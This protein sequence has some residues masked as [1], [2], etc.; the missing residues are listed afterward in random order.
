MTRALITVG[1]VALI[2]IATVAA[3][4]QTAPDPD[5]MNWYHGFCSPEGEKAYNFIWNMLVSTGIVSAGSLAALGLWVR[6]KLKSKDA[7]AV[8]RVI[9]VASQ[10]AS[11]AADG[12]SPQ[13]AA[14]YAVKSTGGTDASA[15]AAADAVP[16]P[17]AS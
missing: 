10:A 8:E 11:I 3:F 15:Q 7:Q 17:K 12:S 16:A 14:H 6:N 4:A 1:A 5:Y 2:L 9:S 13:A